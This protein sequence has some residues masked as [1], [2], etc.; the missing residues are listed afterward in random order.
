MSDDSCAL[1]MV[2]LEASLTASNSNLLDMLPEVPCSFH[3]SL[4]AVELTPKA[5]YLSYNCLSTFQTFNSHLQ[6]VHPV[7]LYSQGAFE[8]VLGLAKLSKVLLHVFVMLDQIPAVI[9]LAPCR[10]LDDGVLDI[11]IS[12][13]GGLKISKEWRDSLHI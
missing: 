3:I 8:V 11:V 5:F 6:L 4:L 1:C 7:L 12:G 10:Q 9:R 13:G 2:L